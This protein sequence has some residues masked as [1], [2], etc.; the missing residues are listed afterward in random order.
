MSR[1]W[2]SAVVPR[3]NKVTR[4]LDLYDDR[5]F[6]GEL[7][8]RKKKNRPWNAHTGLHQQSW[9]EMKPT[10]SLCQ[11]R[12]AAVTAE[13][14]AS[15]ELSVKGCVSTQLEEKIQMQCVG[16]IHPRQIVR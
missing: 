10:R 11:Q 5:Y 16:S 4:D 2:A 6:W 15:P 7:P 14:K 9:P 8:E 3:A 12:E 1:S 13:Q